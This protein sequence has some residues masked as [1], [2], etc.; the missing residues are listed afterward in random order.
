VEAILGAP[1]LRVAQ[2][3]KEG[4]L[5]DQEGIYETLFLPWNW[6]APGSRILHGE[7]WLAL[8]HPSD[9]PTKG[10]DVTLAATATEHLAWVESI[11][12]VTWLSHCSPQDYTT[13][14]PPPW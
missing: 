7:D 10:Q 2:G 8:V 9:T 4:W 5:S 12:D 11:P 14:E 3:V 13:N 6:P 1:A